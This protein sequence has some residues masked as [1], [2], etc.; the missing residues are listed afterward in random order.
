LI[1][2][3]LG[4]IGIA[5]S[6][7][8]A[9][10]YRAKLVLVGRSKLPAREFSG[11]WPGSRQADDAISAK[12]RA[13]ERIGELGGDVLYLDADVADVN[14]MRGVIEQTY[15]R[16]G[17][18]HGVIHGAGIVGEEG[19]LEIKDSDHDTCDVHFR[20]K[21]QGLLVLEA[22]LAGHDLDFCLLMSSLASVLG[23]IGQA[24][25]ASSNLYLDSFARWHNRTSS[26]PWLSVNWDVWR[27]GHLS[28]GLGLGTTLKELGMSAGE[29]LQM[30]ESVLALRTAGQL[31]VS[32]GDLGA[33]ID[34]WIHLESLDARTAATASSPDP[35]APSS[36]S[37]GQ[38][39]PDAP[40]DETEQQIARIWQ[41]A[42]GLDEVG[43]HDHF[44]E[45]GGHSLLAIRI[46]SELRRAFQIHLPVRVLFDAPTVAE[47]STRIKEHLA[48][49]IEALTEEQARQLVSSG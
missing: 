2:G 11:A 31:V 6:E 41:N 7:Y 30:M 36:Q 1:T 45:L 16:F 22:L 5:I 44:S 14:A 47:L 32:T 21:A 9:R 15:Q 17:A 42:L 8:L 25:Y 49:E 18:L 13:I 4:N 23:G 37:R 48:A 19:F 34:Q 33:R 24:A 29:A 39:N 46:V 38:M 35:S 20:A 43:I 27:L 3:G 28:G 12:L 10:T 40:R 26:V